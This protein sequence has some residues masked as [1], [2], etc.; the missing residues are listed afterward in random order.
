MAH[1]DD[2]RC[3]LSLVK[4]VSVAPGPAGYLFE[5][6]GGELA[7]LVAI[8]LGEVIENDAV[9]VPERQTGQKISYYH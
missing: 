6:S 2:S 1:R 5:V 9:N 8:K 3:D 7:D 4:V